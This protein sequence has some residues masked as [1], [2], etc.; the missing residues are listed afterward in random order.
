MA[1]EETVRTDGEPGDQIAFTDKPEGPISAAIIAAGVGAAALGL[2]T[3]LAEASTTVKD[4]LQF[5]DSV[6]PLSGKIIVAVVAWLLAWVALH[7]ALRRQALRNGPCPHHL[8]DPARP[9]HTRN[10]PHLLPSLR[11]RLGGC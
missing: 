10:L 3:T 5:S 6:G 7:I 8:P 1:N 9:G 4:W 11:R 2:L